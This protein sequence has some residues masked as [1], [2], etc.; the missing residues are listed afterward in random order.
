MGAEL[1]NASLTVGAA[2]PAQIT[3]LVVR[4]LVEGGAEILEVRER[5]T[6][7]EQAY[8]EVMGVRPVSGEAL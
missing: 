3:P 8:F 5:V 4:T 7:L 1:R 2:E 6:T